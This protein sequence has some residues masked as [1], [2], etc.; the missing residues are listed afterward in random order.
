MGYALRHATIGLVYLPDHEA[1]NVSLAFCMGQDLDA[2]VNSDQPMATI[3]NNSFGQKGTLAVWA[4]V[5]AVQY[6]MGSSMVS[7]DHRI[8]VKHTV[9]NMP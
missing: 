7:L 8:D 2:I 1:I 4:F 6:M 3:F 9:L 5:V